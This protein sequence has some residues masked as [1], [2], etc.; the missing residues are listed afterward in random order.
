MKLSTA[1]YQSKNQGRPVQLRYCCKEDQ[2]VTRTKNRS[3]PDSGM[4]EL[5]T[6]KLQGG[7]QKLV[8]RYSVLRVVQ[9]LGGK[10]SHK[11]LA[12]SELF[13]NDSS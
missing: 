2:N 12:E 3:K 8:V 5:F 4:H 7:Y 10:T 9:V 13:Q 11:T 1:I 6:S